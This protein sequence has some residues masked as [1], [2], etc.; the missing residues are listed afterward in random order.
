MAENRTK[1]VAPRQK[2][3]VLSLNDARSEKTIRNIQH[4]LFGPIIN[5]KRRAPPTVFAAACA[6]AI[7]FKTKDMPLSEMPKAQKE[8]LDYYST[9]LKGLCRV[10]DR[11]G[12]TSS[13]K[14][15]ILTGIYDIL[16]HRKVSEKIAY[17]VDPKEKSFPFKK[18]F[19]FDLINFSKNLVRFGGSESFIY[20]KHEKMKLFAYNE[21]NSLV[22]ITRECRFNTAAALKELSNRIM[23]YST[24]DLLFSGEY[25]SGIIRKI[26]HKYRQRS[27][28]DNKTVE[29]MQKWLSGMVTGFGI[30]PITIPKKVAI[31]AAGE[32]MAETSGVKG[33]Q[34]DNKERELLDDF[35]SFMIKVTDV[36]EKYGHSSVEKSELLKGFL[37]M[38]DDDKI[39]REFFAEITF[40]SGMDSGTIKYYKYFNYN[41]LH[42]FEGLA[43][44]GGSESLRYLNKMKRFLFLD[45]PSF[46]SLFVSCGANTPSALKELSRRVSRAKRGYSLKDFQKDVKNVIK[47]YEIWPPAF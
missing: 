10:A 25:S 46:F 29:R 11:Y 37:N 18:Y 7:W 14:L 15:E 3:L 20:F 16:S 38:L 41:I 5:F 45:H 17:E 31:A 27:V 6:R 2:P 8:F 26:I 30:R 12:I 42:L 19:A 32:V 28:F 39:A 4:K 35:S 21:I 44:H 47:K 9:I 43:K 33:R 24:P 22:R 36:I 23:R 40:T 1:R 13:G 34:K